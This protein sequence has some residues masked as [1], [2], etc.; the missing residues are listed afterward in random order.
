LAAEKVEK[1]A[2][3][4][5]VKKEVM[6]E[7]MRRGQRQDAGVTLYERP[8]QENKGRQSVKIDVITLEDVCILAEKAELFIHIH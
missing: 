5:M 2:A 3:G 8:Q 7:F 1:P 6:I 4:R